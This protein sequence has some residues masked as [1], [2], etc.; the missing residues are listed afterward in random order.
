MELPDLTVV[1]GDRTVFSHR[2]FT[3][4]DTGVT[5]ITGPSGV[6]KTTLLRALLRAYPDSAFLFQDDR[7]FPWRTVAQHLSDLPERPGG[8]EIQ[9]Y[10]DLVELSGEEDLRPPQLSL[11]MRRRVAL[12]RCLALKRPRYLLDEPFS[13]LDQPLQRRILERLKALGRPTVL[14]THTQALFPLADHR[15]D[16]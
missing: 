8:A 16:L 13:G 2:S 5:F 14:T 4:P 15:I 1:Y 11:G 9:A 6:G 3:L 10:L 12:A 7:L